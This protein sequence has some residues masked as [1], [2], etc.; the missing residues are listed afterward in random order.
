MSLRRTF[1]EFG[2]YD[3]AGGVAL[4]TH[5]IVLSVIV[6]L[7]L[8]TKTAASAFGF[9]CALPVNYFLLRRFVFGQIGRHGQYFSRYIAVTLFTMGLKLPRPRLSC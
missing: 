2:R 3:L 7:E 8:C 4:A 6:D 1:Y 9:A 5:L